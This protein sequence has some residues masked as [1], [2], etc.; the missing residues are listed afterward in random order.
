MKKCPTC[1]MT[2]ADDN[3]CPF[4]GESIVYELVCDA[5]REQIVWNKYFFK[6]TVKNIWFS[7]ICCLVGV[8]KII[9]ARPPM[10]ELLIAA[11]VCAIFSLAVSCFGRSWMVNLSWKYTKSYSMFQ[12]SLWKYGFGLLSVIFFLFIK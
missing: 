4:C 5:D 10:S 1:N 9:V 3:E 6:Y 8:I 11:I 12:L 2:V 7:V